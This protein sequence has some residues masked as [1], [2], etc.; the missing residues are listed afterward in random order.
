MVLVFLV[1]VF[2]AVFATV[3]EEHVVTLPNTTGL[4]S[5][6]SSIAT[7]TDA[8]AFMAGAGPY[9][10]VVFS[11]EGCFFFKRTLAPA[12]SVT[13]SWIR[14]PDPTADLFGFSLAMSPSVWIVG[15]GYNNNTQGAVFS[16]TPP[17]GASPVFDAG[18][19]NPDGPVPKNGF[20]QSVA[21]SGDGSLMIACG[22]FSFGTNVSCF[23]YKNRGLAGSQRVWE[24]TDRIHR[25]ASAGVSGFFGNGLALSSDGT[26]VILSN[27]IPGPPF[28]TSSLFALTLD[29]VSGIRTDPTVD[30]LALLPPLFNRSALVEIGLSCAISGDG[31]VAVA[32]CF[33]DYFQLRSARLSPNRGSV[34]VRNDAAA[35][36]HSARQRFRCGHFHF[37]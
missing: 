21:V 31:N 11:S 36:Q 24:L 17:V 6:G 7:M 30:L 8:T 5:V 27:S 33:S 16:L 35:A 29:P 15:A 34:G 32:S 2:G 20:G 23:V 37:F 22:F 3:D 14:S 4:V 19:V 12:F 1:C 13:Y 26:T 18:L 10:P 9:F 25:P 28:N